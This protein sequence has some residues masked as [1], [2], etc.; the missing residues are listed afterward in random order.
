MSSLVRSNSSISQWAARHDCAA[1][2]W[3]KCCQLEFFFIMEINFYPSV[4]KLELILL[5]L[6]LIL[7]QLMGHWNSSASC[8]K[9]QYVTTKSPQKCFCYKL[10]ENNWSILSSFEGGR[11]ENVSV[12]TW[13][14]CVPPPLSAF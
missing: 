6:K 10:F 13:L 7:L 8:G 4:G 1:W 2:N 3:Q 11:R 5:Q 9:P 14:F 12:L